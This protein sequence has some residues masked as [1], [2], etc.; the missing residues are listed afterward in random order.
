[1]CL[2]AKECCWPVQLVELVSP[3]GPSVCCERSETPRARLAISVNK[4][5]EKVWIHRK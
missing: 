2:N 1:M 5:D 4:L 3:M